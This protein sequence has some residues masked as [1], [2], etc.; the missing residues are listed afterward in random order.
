MPTF[1]ENGYD[2][3]TPALNPTADCYDCF[4]V[5]LANVAVSNG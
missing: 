5:A 2:T 1:D 4:V 3:S